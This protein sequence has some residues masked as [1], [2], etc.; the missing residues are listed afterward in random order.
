VELPSC[1]KHGLVDVILKEKVISVRIVHDDILYPVG[2]EQ[3]LEQ[4][5]VMLP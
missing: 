3:T 4:K 1:G 5:Q 2:T